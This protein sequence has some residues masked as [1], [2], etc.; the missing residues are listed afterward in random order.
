MPLASVSLILVRPCNPTTVK[1]VPASDVSLRELKLDGYRLQVSKEGRQVRRYT[2]CGNVCTERLQRLVTAHT[3]TRYGFLAAMRR[4]RQTTQRLR[5]RFAPR[6]TG[7]AHAAAASADDNLSALSAPSLPF[8]QF[9]SR[10]APDDD[11]SL[12]SLPRTSDSKVRRRGVQS[13]IEVKSSVT[14]MCRMPSLSR[15]EINE[16]ASEWVANVLPP[17]LRPLRCRKNL[18]PWILKHAGKGR[19]R[20]RS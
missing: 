6:W 4:G 3:D 13:A 19:P 17:L 9:P 1:A 5:I 12:I 10:A 8:A 2:P 7:S 20:Q 11:L 18:W 16:R 14:K 15:D